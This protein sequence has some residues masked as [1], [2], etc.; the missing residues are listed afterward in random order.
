[1][2]CWNETCFLT[3]LPICR[4][5]KVVAFPII[6]NE[7]INTGTLFD[8]YKATGNYYALSLPFYGK[9]DDYGRL[10]DI[11]QNNSVNFSL[12]LIKYHIEKNNLSLIDDYPGND[13]ANLKSA[14]GLISLIERGYL[15]DAYHNPA[16]LLMMHE[17]AFKALIDEVG[18]R[19][20][21]SF[22]STNKKPLSEHIKFA[23]RYIPKKVSDTNKDPVE[24]IF[25]RD[26]SAFSS[27][28]T[29]RF[30]KS[31]EISL[32][33][34]QEWLIDDSII[35]DFKDYYLFVMGLEIMRK[36]I[37][38]TIGKGSQTMEMLLH[39]RVADFV[40][41]HVVSKELEVDIDD[42]LNPLKK[43]FYADDF[44]ADELN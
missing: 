11:S 31:W 14:E 2:G 18:S 43:T 26:K 13:E 1:M 12:E 15:K 5:E 10:E 23:I 8:E 32:A 40:H 38:P 16:H 29:N 36:P 9:Y 19:I 41:K 35:D 6:K 28:L 17:G 24:A 33:F 37:T 44:E 3:N 42:D 30:F 39:K 34:G 7:S 27:F 21:Y 25:R 4:G 20:P 22:N